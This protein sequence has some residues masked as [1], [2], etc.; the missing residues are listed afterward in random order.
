[1][2][3]PKFNISYRLIR[4]RTCVYQGVRNVSFSENI[5]NILHEWSIMLAFIL[6][7]QYIRDSARS[8]EL[9]LAKL[10]KLSLSKIYC[11]TAPCYSHLSHTSEII[12]INQKVG[13]C[14]C[15]Y[16][17]VSWII[18]FFKILYHSQQQ[19]QGS[20]WNK[21][22]AW[23]SFKKRMLEVT[24]YLWQNQIYQNLFYISKLLTIS[25]MPAK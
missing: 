16:K 19:Q 8:Y 14:H 7:N 13:P 9:E 2:E 23:I 25:Y 12:E 22:D 6:I 5:A 11:N 17:K 24:I 18:K 1:M 21:S 3:N 15:C 20:K 4:T 10:A